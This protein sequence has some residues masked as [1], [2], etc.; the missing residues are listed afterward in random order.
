MISIAQDRLM[1]S[2]HQL[3]G[4]NRPVIFV[5]KLILCMSV[6]IIWIGRQ[7]QMLMLPL[8]SPSIRETIQTGLVVVVKL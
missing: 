5:V 4:L 3:R 7:H 1:L 8:L 6:G 2:P